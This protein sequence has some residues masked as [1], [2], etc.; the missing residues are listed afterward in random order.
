MGV[1][2]RDLY[3]VLV[4]FLLSLC[5]SA[6]IINSYYSFGVECPL[7][8]T[9]VAEFSCLIFNYGHILI[10]SPYLF[11]FG[12]NGLFSQ[13]DGFKGLLFF[14]LLWYALFFMLFLLVFISAYFLLFVIIPFL[15]KKL[16][17]Q[18]QK[19]KSGMLTHRS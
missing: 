17:K 4:S 5:I 12:R 2:R 13:D 14:G 8:L 9:F 6:Y 3:K 15:L 18:K 1:F 16:Y 7:H 10:V 19:N 11:V